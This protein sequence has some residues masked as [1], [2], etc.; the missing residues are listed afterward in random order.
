[1]VV[2]ATLVFS[3]VIEKYDEPNVT[4]SLALELLKA[5]EVLSWDEIVRNHFLKA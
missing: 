2:A 5:K 4:H 3:Y 1:M